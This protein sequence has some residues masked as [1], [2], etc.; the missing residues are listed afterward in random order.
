[1]LVFR[2][3]NLWTKTGKHLE[4]TNFRFHDSFRRC[5]PLKIPSNISP[6]EHLGPWENGPLQRRSLSLT[7]LKIIMTLENHHVQIGNWNIFKWWIFHCH[8]NFSRGNALFVGWAKL[9]RVGWLA[10]KTAWLNKNWIQSQVT[11]GR[12]RPQA[13]WKQ[14]PAGERLFIQTLEMQSLLRMVME[15]KIYYAFRRWLDTPMILWQYNWM[16]RERNYPIEDLGA[17]D[18][19]KIEFIPYLS[20]SR[21]Q[22][23]VV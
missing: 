7:P 18:P 17:I 10:K 12:C 20:L 14:E 3:V 5:T 22:L 16:P 2:G 13:K 1:M 21:H 9:R 6:K 15:P 23:V 4:T 8:F 11:G 19:Q